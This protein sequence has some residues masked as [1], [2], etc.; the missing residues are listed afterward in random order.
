M[1][2]KNEAQ[3]LKI[4]NGSDG[5]KDAKIP[6][7]YQICSGS[8]C[9]LVSLKQHFRAT[10]SATVAEICLQTKLLV[11]ETSQASWL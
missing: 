1:Q 8:R 4:T 10:E 6:L 11:V 9:R 5:P 2:S 7:I 3:N